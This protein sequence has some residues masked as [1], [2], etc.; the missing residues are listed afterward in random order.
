MPTQALKKQGFIEPDDLRRVKLRPL[1][2]L[3]SRP[4]AVADSPPARKRIGELLIERGKLDAQALERALRLQEDSGEKIGTL[5]VTLGIVS[6]RDVAESLAAQLELPLLDATGYPEFPIL[7][8][9]VSARFLRESRAL[10]VR[11]DES[12]L[13]L[14]M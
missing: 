12:E 13:T 14:A 3:A 7:E 10:P 1:D 11:E 5:L 2:T 8:E 6:Q 9:R 4:P